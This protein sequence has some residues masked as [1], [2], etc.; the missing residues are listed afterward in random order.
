MNKI[1]LL[2]L[3]LIGVAAHAADDLNV[4]L[5]KRFG[6]G[7]GAGYSFP[8]WSNKFDDDADGGLMYDL[9]A[10]YHFTDAHSLMF[11]WAK[12]DWSGTDVNANVYDLM[13]LSRTKSTSRLT[14]VWGLGAGVAN[15]SS[16]NPE[17]NLKLSLRG[18]I[19]L[20]YAIT[21]DLMAQAAVDYQYINQMP[22]ERGSLPTG[23]INA[24]VPQVNVT[25][26]FG[27][28]GGAVAS[29]GAATGVVVASGDEDNDGVINAKDKCPDTTQGLPVTEYGCLADDAVTTEVEVYFKTDSAELTDAPKTALDELALFMEEN[30]ETKV[31]IQGFTDNIGPSDVNKDLSK[32]RANTVAEYLVDQGIEPSRL[33]TAGLGEQSPVGDNSN[34][35]GRAVNR[36]VMAVITQ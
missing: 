23:D 1:F 22:G 36:R 35:T 15:L 19:G 32:D 21:A 24:L 5:A 20:E 16:I 33:E 30:P 3:F 6:I 11:T 26:F 34:S 27:G 2:P 18:R 29:A 13:F 25:Y 7:A 17:D 12:H 10:R 9:H 31:E 8:I 4:N 14:P 28:P